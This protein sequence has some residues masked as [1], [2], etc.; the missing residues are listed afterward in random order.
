MS[1]ISALAVFT[2]AVAFAAAAALVFRHVRRLNHVIRTLQARITQLE[3]ELATR[4]AP[5]VAFEYNLVTREALLH[6]KNDGG[7]AEFRA[8]LLVEGPLSH[9]VDGELSAVWQHSGAGRAIVRRGQRA[10]LRLAQ[11]DLSVFPYAQWQIFG[12][13]RESAFSVR[14]MHTSVIGGDPDTHA[15]ALI[16]QVSLSS[17]PEP[18][19]PPPHCTIALQ[20][21]EA[22]RLR[23]F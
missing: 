21:F 11:L 19:G 12:S 4:P 1:Y 9:P 10:T 13:R 22:V 5:R 18:S 16:L 14:A 2:A 7:D 20:P 23:G 17:S 6:L 15:P 3:R 8:S